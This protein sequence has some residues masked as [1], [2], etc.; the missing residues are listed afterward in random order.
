MLEET[1]IEFVTREEREQELLQKAKCFVI[2]GNE[3]LI[4]SVAYLLER[5]FFSSGILAC[6]LDSTILINGICSNCIADSDEF[7]RRTVEVVKLFLNSGFVCI[8]SGILKPI[9]L[10]NNNDFIFINIDETAQKN[11]NELYFKIEAEEIE[12]GVNHLFKSISSNV[13]S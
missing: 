6:V 9:I 7:Q 4:H 2:N 1:Y 13:N 11:E 10:N 12:S 8:V 5:R 3:E